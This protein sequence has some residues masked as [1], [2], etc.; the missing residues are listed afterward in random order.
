LSPCWP[1]VKRRPRRLRDAKPPR[2]RPAWWPRG[3]LVEITGHSVSILTERAL[4]PEEFTRDRL[5][6]EI[7][8]L[9]TMREA[10]RDDKARMEADFALGRLEQVRATLSF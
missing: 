7:L 10:M 1:A 3:G 5:D 4:P 8:R 2:R 6:E 9:E